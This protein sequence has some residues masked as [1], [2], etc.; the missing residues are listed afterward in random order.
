MVTIMTVPNFKKYLQDLVGGIHW[1]GDT[2]I[3][4]GG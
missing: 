1:M 3:A 4:I 2:L